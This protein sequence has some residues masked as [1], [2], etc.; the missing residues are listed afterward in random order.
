MR[1]FHEA[2]AKKMGAV[3]V[4][5]ETPEPVVEQP[6]I[7]HPAPRWTRQLS[8]DEQRALSPEDFD[9]YFDWRMGVAD[10]V[11]SARERNGARHQD[12]CLPD[13]DPYNQFGPHHTTRAGE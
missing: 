9:S 13:S 11:C 1:A 12:E 8:Y 2:Q 7:E 6:K 4:I 5:D 10:R 3:I